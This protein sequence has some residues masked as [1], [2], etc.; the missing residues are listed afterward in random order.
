MVGIYVY[1]FMKNRSE[2]LIQSE[3]EKSNSNDEN[4]QEENNI[5]H[6]IKLRLNKDTKT[7]FYRKL[8]VL[9]DRIE[10]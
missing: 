10:V 4:I 6:A 2:D 1:N 3:D 5:Q 9:N 7:E 8:Q